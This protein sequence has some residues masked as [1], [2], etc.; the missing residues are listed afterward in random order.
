MKNSTCIL[1]TCLLLTLIF[2]C[3]TE[4]KELKENSPRAVARVW[5][6]NY[7]QHNDYDLA[8]SYSTAETAAMIDTIKG[9]IFPDQENAEKIPFKIKAIRC[10]QTKGATIAKCTCT[11]LED[12]TSFTEELTLV[13]Q[14]GQW[15]VDAIEENEDML[16]DSDIEKMTQDFEKNLDRMLEK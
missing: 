14:D 15:L 16:K 8:K 6:E 5:L 1:I 12:E 10:R 9:M 7:Y 4:K 3:T 2:A 13:Q 11:Y